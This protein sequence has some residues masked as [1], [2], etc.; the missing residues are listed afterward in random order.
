MLILKIISFC[1]NIIENMCAAEKFLEE[2]KLQT[3]I[4]NKFSLIYC[5]KC[6]LTQM[7]GDILQ[8]LLHMCRATILGRI[9]RYLYF[10]FRKKIR[11]DDMTTIM[12]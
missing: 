12:L 11:F 6:M 7:F 9:K 5:M 3:Q 10:D 8:N 1:S 2:R 4:V